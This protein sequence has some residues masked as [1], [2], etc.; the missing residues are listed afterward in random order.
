MS[1]IKQSRTMLLKVGEKSKLSEGFV[2]VD[3]IVVK[4]WG[5]KPSV[6][7][8]PYMNIMKSK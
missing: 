1:C 3:Q 6:N 7:D 4:E 2:L 8:I 5:I